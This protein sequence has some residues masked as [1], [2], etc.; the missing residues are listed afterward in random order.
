MKYIIDGK[1]LASLLRK[2]WKLAA[3]ENGGV[4]NWD[5]YGESLFPDEGE[6]YE[7]IENKSDEELLKNYEK[8]KE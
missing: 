6:T 4:D 7:D 5:W 2:E 8:V 1:R 3:L